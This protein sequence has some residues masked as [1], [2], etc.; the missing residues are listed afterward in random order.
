MGPVSVPITHNS[1]VNN[2]NNSS[3]TIRPR[4]P[5]LTSPSELGYVLAT[6][7]ALTVLGCGLLLLPSAGSVAKADPAP[8]PPSTGSFA[9]FG[10]ALSASIPG[11][12]APLDQPPPTTDL[13]SPGQVLAN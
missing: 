2:M 1:P 6:L 7:V 13:A 12:G 4:P 11:V 10:G 3:I 9:A 5:R 8:Q